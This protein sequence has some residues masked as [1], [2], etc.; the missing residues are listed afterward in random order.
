[1]ILPDLNLIIYAHNRSS[2]SHRAA[3]DW[4]E[5]TL[6]N[7][8]PVALCWA[9]MLGFIRL[10]TQRGVFQ[11]PLQ[12]SAACNEVRSWLAQPQVI[13]LEPGR[14]HAS[15]VLDLLEE[16]GAAGNLTTDAHLAALAIEHQCELCSTD[17]D[18][19]RFSGLQWT[20]PLA[21]GR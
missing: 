20:N 14:R 6:S 4:W 18:F 11:T 17:S 19:N 3:K 1:M 7:P 10:S 5:T 21:K 8:R 15:I 16:L 12:V 9:V 2:G 13:I